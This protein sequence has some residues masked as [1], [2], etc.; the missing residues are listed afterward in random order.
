MKLHIKIIYSN[1][2]TTK[3]IR[4]FKISSETGK[5]LFE[6]P[7]FKADTQLEECIKGKIKKIAEMRNGQLL[8]EVISE[9]QSV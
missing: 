3:I 6:I 2:E 1:F 4:C 5:S 8:V 9:L 7:V